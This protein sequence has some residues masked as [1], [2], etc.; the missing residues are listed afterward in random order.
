ML[1]NTGPARLWLRL[2]ATTNAIE[3]R[4]RARL[5]AEFAM[6]LPRF[7]AMAQLARNPRGMVM[8]ELTERLMVTKGNTTGL[9]DRLVADGLAERI[10]TPGD[11]RS[12]IVR[13]SAEGQARFDTVA[14]VMR[15]WIHE[16]LSGL[17]PGQRE[18]LDALLGILHETTRQGGEG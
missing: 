14:P 13:L 4:L 18:Q 1:E 11:R 6:T 5:A 2:L 10:A 3:A 8:G 12:A 16:A 15:G 9:V 17:E 7:D